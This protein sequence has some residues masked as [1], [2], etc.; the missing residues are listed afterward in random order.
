MHLK[1]IGKDNSKISTTSEVILEIRE[2]FLN[3]IISPSISKVG[4]KKTTNK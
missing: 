4:C 1:I 3:R 2:N